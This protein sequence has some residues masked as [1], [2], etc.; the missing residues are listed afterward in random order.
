MFYQL[1]GATKHDVF[2]ASDIVPLT[3]WVMGG[4]GFGAQLSTYR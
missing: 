4:P 2:N 1:F 3:L